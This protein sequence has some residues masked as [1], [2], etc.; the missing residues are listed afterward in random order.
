MIAVAFHFTEDENTIKQWEYVLSHFEADYLYCVGG[1]PPVSDVLSKAACIQSG[2]E[3]PLD[4]PV[5]LLAPINGLYVQGNVSLVD[6]DHPEDACYWFGSDFLHFDPELLGGRQPDHTV[7]VPVDTK[8][9]MFSHVV[10]AVVAWD[11]RQKGAR[12]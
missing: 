9:Q 11:R 7:Y 12:G 8:D 5:I 1:Q 4:I 3:L 2:D 6:F 10:W